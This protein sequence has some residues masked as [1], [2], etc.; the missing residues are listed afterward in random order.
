MA[1]SLAFIFASPLVYAGITLW[2]MIIAWGLAGLFGPRWR[3][4]GDD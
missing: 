3:E 4:P 1:E 2:L